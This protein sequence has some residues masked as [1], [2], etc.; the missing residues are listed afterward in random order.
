MYVEKQKEKNFNVDNVSQQP[1]LLTIIN[2]AQSIANAMAE[3]WT[4]AVIGCR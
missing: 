2:A 1:V 3:Q 4:E